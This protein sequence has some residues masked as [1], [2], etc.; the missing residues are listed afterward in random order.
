VDA[1]HIGV[2]GR[3]DDAEADGF[4]DAQARR[5]KQVK[6]R[7]PLRRDLCEQPLELPPGEEASLVVLMGTPA[8]PARQHDRGTHVAG[9]QSGVRGM[10][11]ARAQRQHRVV[12]RAVAQPVAVGSVLP[13][14][15]VDEPAQPLFV[16]SYD[17]LSS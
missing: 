16:E 12:Y 3:I 13:T 9:H 2:H 14:E 4:G 11:Q 15:P 17:R 7:A 6:E 10:A 1:W 5:R 8:P